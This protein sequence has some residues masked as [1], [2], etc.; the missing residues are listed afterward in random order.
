MP[1]HCRKEVEKAEDGK[2]GQIS[3]E[4]PGIKISES[5]GGQQFRDSRGDNTALQHSIFMSSGNINLTKLTP[6]VCALCLSLA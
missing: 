1:K 6:M 5:M 2:K 4:L 3:Q